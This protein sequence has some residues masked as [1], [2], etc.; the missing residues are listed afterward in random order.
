MLCRC[1]CFLNLSANCYVCF[2]WE[3]RWQNFIV[4]SIGSVTLDE[5]HSQIPVQINNIAETVINT[6]DGKSYTIEGGYLD[7]GIIDTMKDLWVNFIGAVVFSVIGFFYEK[8]NEKKNLAGDM[9]L[10][11]ISAAEYE[12]QEE[13]VKAAYMING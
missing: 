1:S 7:V 3:S 6:A 5:T 2:L 13:K 8:N 10:R 11:P 9:R 4:T 12:A